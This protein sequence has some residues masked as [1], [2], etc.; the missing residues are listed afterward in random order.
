MTNSNTTTFDTTPY[1]AL[2]LRLS[3]GT[4]FLAHAGLKVF[5]FTMAG[6]AGYFES[7]GLPGFLAYI[8]VAA[9]ALGGLALMAGFA[10]RTVSLALIP[11]LLGAL[12]FAHAG[13]GWVF[14]NKGGGW[15]YPAFLAAAIL[16]QALIGSGAYSLSD[17]FKSQS[18]K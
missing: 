13:N 7:I 3:L 2:I 12:F 17:Y 9:E 4:M 6:A 14:S 16:V 11:V 18:A 1:G 5:V 8:T 10:T 15:E